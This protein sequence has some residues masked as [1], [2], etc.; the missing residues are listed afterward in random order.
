MG[1]KASCIVPSV[2]PKLFE[3]WENNPWAM[4]LG[5]L[6]METANIWKTVFEGKTASPL[7][8]WNLFYERDMALLS[9]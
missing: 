4:S 8:A 7:Y 1:L 9:E 3:V 2:A 6:G 5:Y